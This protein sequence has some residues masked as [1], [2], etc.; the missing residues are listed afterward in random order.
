MIRAGNK[1]N[2]VN[3]SENSKPPRK[4]YSETPPKQFPTRTFPGGCLHPPNQTPPGNNSTGYLPWVIEY[5]HEHDPEH[6]HDD[7]GTNVAHFAQ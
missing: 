6:D 7:G 2:L 5:D 1:P 4:E 3:K